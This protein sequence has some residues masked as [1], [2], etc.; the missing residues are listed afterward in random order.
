MPIYDFSCQDCATVFEEL[1]AKD[2]AVVVCPQCGSTRTVQ[3][4][5]APSPLKRG[6]FPFK[7]GPVHPMASRM[8]GGCGGGGCP[9]GGGFS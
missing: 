7:P 4:I 2:K 1:P 8:A 9:G 3:M 6:A 5:S